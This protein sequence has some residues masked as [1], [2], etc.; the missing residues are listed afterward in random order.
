MTIYV[1]PVSGGKDSQVVL[2][3]AVEEHGPENVR[4]VHHFTGIDHPLTMAHMDYMAELYGVRI[5]HTANPKYKDMW[6]LLDKKN[7]I[8]GRLARF[9]TDELKIQAFNHW[10][11]S[12][13]DPLTDLVILMGMRAQ[14]SLPRM[15]S[16]GELSPADEFSLFD[17]NPKKV[18]ARFR[19]VRVRLPI[20]DKS[21]AWV[22]EYLRKRGEKVNPL[23]ARGHKRVGCYPCILAG[24]KDY[25][26]A[27]RDP[28][29]RETIV[30]LRDFKALLVQA[31]SIEKTDAILPKDLDEL[32]EA[33]DD[34]FGFLEEDEDDLAGGCQWCAVTAGD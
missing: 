10:L 28:V 7:R 25:R 26:L 12:Q 9:C 34:P 4:A 20:V 2:S 22:F 16:Y 19:A 31:K 21:T 24:T 18:R 13:P 29:G 23:Y 27:A 32:L 15:K 6:E 1:V 14:E 33:P 3:M 11:D 5:D 8:P 30:K 17:F